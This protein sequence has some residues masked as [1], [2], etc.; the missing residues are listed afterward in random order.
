M[1][2]NDEQLAAVEYLEGP[3]L[4]LAG[5][6]TGKTQLLSA[7]VAYILEKTDASP[8]NILC[9][10]F[11]EAG[12]E[13]MRDRLKTMIGNAADDVTISTYHAFGRNILER[14]QNYA[15]HPERE[16]NTPIDETMQYRIV[17]D[18]LKKLPA[19]DI[20]KKTDPKD[21][22]ATISQAKAARL[23]P[24]DLIKIAKQNVEDSN[25]IAAEIIEPL[26]A[27]IPRMRYAAAR[28]QV[29]LPIAEILAKYTSEQPITGTIERSANVML[30]SLNK[31]F[32]ECEA[33]EKPSVKKLSDWKNAHIERTSDGKYRLKDHIANKKLQSLANIMAEYEAILES[34][35]LFDFNDMI[36]QSI[37]YLKEDDGF[38]LSQSEIF[39][40]ILL[41][42]FQDTNTSQFDIIKLL[43][44]YEN[45]II[46]AVGDDDQA[47]Y[48][49][50]SA[51]ASKFLE[52]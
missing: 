7:K 38:R 23:T 27:L 19:M 32:E 20:L 39:Q 8:S 11:T 26:S 17:L 49:L 43:T 29:Y 12:A 1:K 6:G 52:I 13:N 3:L 5:P 15:E 4:V 30:R 47:I 35:S 42:E 46:M 40:Y 21:I 16:L 24:N 33:M 31:A 2:L 41:D 25:A 36:E 45:P 28:E 9:L 18:I 37:K 44:D 50:L 22:I 51:N 48:A 14:Y 10:T 34:K